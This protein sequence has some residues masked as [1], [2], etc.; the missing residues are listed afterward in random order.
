[1][2]KVYK[3]VYGGDPGECGIWSGSGRDERMIMSWQ[4]L[5][6]YGIPMSRVVGYG[7]RQLAA[8]VQ[9]YERDRAPVDAD[10]LISEMFDY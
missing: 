7:Q 4:D 8:I 10:R 5:E 2:E 6:R 9:Q 1:M 3:V